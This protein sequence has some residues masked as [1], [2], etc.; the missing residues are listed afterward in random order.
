MITCYFK[1]KKIKTFFL[2]IH[3]YNPIFVPK[4]CHL[5]KKCGIISNRLSEKHEKRTN[6]I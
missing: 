1:N 3:F 2:I 6:E 4:N 5:Y